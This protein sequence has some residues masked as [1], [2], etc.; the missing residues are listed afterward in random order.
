MA[1]DKDKKGLH[2]GTTFEQTEVIGLIGV[3]YQNISYP[4]INYCFCTPHL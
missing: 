3:I 4:N 1:I 2:T